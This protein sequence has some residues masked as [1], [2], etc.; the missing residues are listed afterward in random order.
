M[1]QDRLLRP[2]RIPRFPRVLCILCRHFRVWSVFADNHPRPWIRLSE[3][4]LHDDPSLRS[5]RCC[6][7]AT[8]VALRQAAETRFVPGDLRSPGRNR[9]HY[10][11]RH[12][13]RWWRLCRNVHSRSW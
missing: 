7:P 6:A 12:S 10:L 1:G 9:L 3:S 2:I 4:Q 11:C 5:G 13:Q 8:D